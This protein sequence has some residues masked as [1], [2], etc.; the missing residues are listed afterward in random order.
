M[1]RQHDSNVVLTVPTHSKC[2]DKPMMDLEDK[3]LSHTRV[4]EYLLEFL[5]RDAHSPKEVKFVLIMHMCR[6]PSAFDITDTISEPDRNRR[7]GAG[8]YAT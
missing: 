4:L 5:A 6:D 3:C 1:P 7:Q 8:V 2:D